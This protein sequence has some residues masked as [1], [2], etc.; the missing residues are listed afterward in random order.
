MFGHEEVDTLT[1]EQSVVASQEI[2]SD[3]VESVIVGQ[4]DDQDNGQL[5]ESSENEHNST[6]DINNHDA[7]SVLPET[8][9]D[10]KVTVSTEGVRSVLSE[11]ED[12]SLGM[13][14]ARSKRTRQ[15][16][17]S[18]RPEPATSTEDTDSTVTDE[19]TLAVTG[20]ARRSRMSGAPSTIAENLD[21]QDVQDRQ[22]RGGMD[23]SDIDKAES[24]DLLSQGSAAPETESDSQEGLSES[25]VSSPETETAPAG[26]RRGKVGR[27]RKR[28]QESTEME[29]VVP[30][31]PTRK[32]RRG[33]A[34]TEGSVFTERV[35]EGSKNV[36]HENI[37]METPVVISQ[38][39]GKKVVSESLKIET[40][41]EIEGNGMSGIHTNRRQT[42]K[43][44]Q[45]SQEPELPQGSITSRQAE[46]SSNI[47]EEDEAMDVGSNRRSR[48][49]ALRNISQRTNKPSVKRQTRTSLQL[50]SKD[51]DLADTEHVVFN[52]KA[53]ER[54]SR[55]DDETPANEQ[56]SAE[57]KNVVADRSREDEGTIIRRKRAARKSSVSTEDA[58]VNTVIDILSS[59][60]SDSL[61][62][63][64]V[65]GRFQTKS[66]D[67]PVVPKVKTPN[68][69]TSNGEEAEE[70]PKTRKSRKSLDVKEVQLSPDPVTAA[71]T[72]SSRRSQ[73]KKSTPSL[74]EATTLLQD[75][76]KNFEDEEH[77]EDEESLAS[78]KKVSRKTAPMKST[79]TVTKRVTRS[80]QKK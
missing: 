67:T 29:G 6:S 28:K 43:S 36:E 2:L 51:S 27:G 32:T 55:G 30:R 22:S 47:A 58:L 5:L 7:D 64:E 10:P 52:D 65:S 80:R 77:I 53:S 79:E 76:A 49:S 57:Q 48:R 72:L 35:S 34:E 14:P 70:T 37:S 54:D 45:E 23:V 19:E 59:R 75:S 33:A 42:R 8:M 24:S 17:R 39:E 71:G 69:D 38:E 13:Q 15:S 62:T 26:P 74:P 44:A 60:E 41:P 40:S 63:E 21:I 31:P 20:R 16:R 25:L 18:I 46:A 78:P 4:Q 68:S 1:S 61:T 12:G 9:K 11:K 66:H 50:T 73:R 56:S 3:S